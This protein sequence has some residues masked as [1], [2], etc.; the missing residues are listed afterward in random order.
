MTTLITREY[1]TFYVYKDDSLVLR[2]GDRK[3]AEEE[4]HKLSFENPMSHVELKSQVLIEK[5]L[6]SFAPREGKRLRPQ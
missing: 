6:R 3:K 5:E 1:E 2:T 4:A